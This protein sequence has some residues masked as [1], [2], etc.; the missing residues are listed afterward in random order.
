MTTATTDTATALQQAQDGLGQ[1]Q[2]KVSSLEAERAT[3]LAQLAPTAARG[4]ALELRRLKAQ[5]RNL[6]ED[7]DA[8]RGCCST[9]PSASAYRCLSGHDAQRSG[10]TGPAESR[11]NVC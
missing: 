3:T 6:D 2:A 8:G 7:L 5:L 10:S 4:E 9:G 1:A 11:L